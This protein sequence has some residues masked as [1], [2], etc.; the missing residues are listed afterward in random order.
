[1]TYHTIEGTFVFKG[2]GSISIAIEVLFLLQNTLVKISKA[3]TPAKTGV[4]HRGG[5][6]FP[7][8]P[9]SRE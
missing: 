7:G 1:V 8:F 4:S 3:V 5:I 6:D 2:N 9:F